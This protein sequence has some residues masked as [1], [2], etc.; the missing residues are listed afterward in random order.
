M[1]KL[2]I[3]AMRSALLAHSMELGPIKRGNKVY[4]Y[5]KYCDKKP[6]NSFQLFVSKILTKHA[7]QTSSTEVA[8]SLKKKYSVFYSKYEFLPDYSYVKLTNREYNKVLD[9]CQLFGVDES[10]IIELIYNYWVFVKKN[11]LIGSYQ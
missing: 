8:E 4:V 5:Y 1:K 11:V 2:P 9:M 10:Y 3:L 7:M 6:D